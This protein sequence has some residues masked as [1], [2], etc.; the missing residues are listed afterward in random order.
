MKCVKNFCKKD[1]KFVIH[2]RANDNQD[3]TAYCDDHIPLIFTLEEARHLQLNIESKNE[4]N[5]QVISKYSERWN[6]YCI[7]C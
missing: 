4:K 5:K 2:H 1:A 6:G 7:H 3:A